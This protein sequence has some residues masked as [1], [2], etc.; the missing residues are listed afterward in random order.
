MLKN[1]TA[2]VTAWGTAQRFGDRAPGLP[3]DATVDDVRRIQMLET[4]VSYWQAR[5]SSPGA[6]GRALYRTQPVGG[7]PSDLVLTTGEAMC[8]GAITNLRHFRIAENQTHGHVLDIDVGGSTQT[9]LAVDRRCL[10]RTDRALGRTGERPVEFWHF[11]V[12][13]SGRALYGLVTDGPS[14]RNGVVVLDDT[15]VMREGDLIDGVRLTSPAKPNQI[16]LDDR[17]RAATL[18]AMSGGNYTIFLTPDI[19]RFEGTRKVVS[20]NTPLDLDGDGDADALLYQ[21]RF[22]PDSGPTFSLAE[23][24]IYIAA[25][26]RY[27]GTTDEVPAVIFYP[28]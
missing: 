23:T 1:C 14:H 6:F 4:G 7:A 22:F 25:L 3:A 16:R 11:D 10:A 20:E 28:F 15:V 2:L 19:D 12:S 8:G 27:P 9:A 24:G 13:S 18:W 21:F 26:L 5:W 17:G